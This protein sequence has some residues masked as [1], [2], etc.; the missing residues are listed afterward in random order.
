MNENR[1]KKFWK[2]KILMSCNVNNNVYDIFH[3][4]CTN[5]YFN[6]PTIYLQIEIIRNMNIKVR[7]N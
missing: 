1:I 3:H 5:Y 6:T 2:E 4:H 7:D